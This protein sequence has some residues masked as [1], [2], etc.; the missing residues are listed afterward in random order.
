MSKSREKQPKVKKTIKEPKKILSFSD[1]KEFLFIFCIP[2]LVLIIFMCVNIVLSIQSTKRTTADVLMSSFKNYSTYSDSRLNSLID[3][4]LLFDSNPEIS[5]IIKS[6]ESFSDEDINVMSDFLRY[7]NKSSPLIGT[8]AVLSQSSDTVVTSDGSYTFDEYF[9]GKCK[10]TS[11]T[12]VFFKVFDIY[13]GSAYK[14]LSP[15]TVTESAKV[16]IAIPVIIRRTVS[17]NEKLIFIMVYLDKLFENAASMFD[18]SDFFVLDNFSG[19]SYNCEQKNHENISDTLI[20]KKLMNSQT[21]FSIKEKHS[22]KYTIFSYK[23]SDTILGYTYYIKIPNIEFYKKQLTSI[24]ITILSTIFAIFVAVFILFRNTNT[25]FYSLNKIITKLNLPIDAKTPILAN[26]IDEVTTITEKNKYYMSI[27]QE[28]ALISFLN[29][30]SQIRLNDEILLELPFKKEYYMSLIIQLI[31][32]SKFIS[33]FPACNHEPLLSSVFSTLKAILA[34]ESEKMDLFFI[35]AEQNSLYVIVNGDSD[36][37]IEEYITERKK[38]II[39]ILKQDSKLIDLIIGKGTIECGLDGLK[40]SHNTAIKNLKNEFHSLQTAERASSRQKLNI[41]PYKMEQKFFSALINDDISE[42]KA[43]AD[44]LLNP[45]NKT[46]SEA[47]IKRLYQY[48]FDTIFR[49]LR[50]KNIT[51]TEELAENTIRQKLA[52]ESNNTIYK[53]LIIVLNSF[54]TPKKKTDADEIIKFVNDN[55]AD[56]LISLDYVS[57]NFNL[58]TSTCSK[59]IRQAL[60]MGFHEYLSMLRCENAKKLLSETD[61]SV[62]EILEQSG[63]TNRQTFA[64]VFKK[65]TG[66]SPSEYRNT[67][68]SKNK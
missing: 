22:G 42:A 65:Q 44:A 68:K 37:V 20:Y 51:L 45:Q 3:S 38:A 60:N 54:E 49:V 34:D 48:M 16:N 61:L 47:D 30:S 52:T 11:Y 24:L 7:F 32:T 12:P 41:F 21:A 57:Q 15:C 19:I 9:N 43:V 63:F 13:D 40:F 36:E 64:R 55:F 26:I 14:M 25:L 23:S 53:T 27:A 33:E 1:A 8:S 46:L 6:P 28:N 31:P 35:S 17:R 66:L 59:I 10:T 5:R 18:N 62:S 58:P 2:V 39:N 67:M 50:I 29:N 56:S 4:S